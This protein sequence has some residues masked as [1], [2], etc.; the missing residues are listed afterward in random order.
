MK[1][2]R[3]LVKT[4]KRIQDNKTRK[5]GSLFGFSSKKK[6]TTVILS[7]LYSK[8]GNI[9]LK[10]LESKF[11]ENI[12]KLKQR[13][14][15]CVT[16]CLKS[17]HDDK[18]RDQMNTM[19]RNNSFYDWGNICGHSLNVKQCRD[20][21]YTYSKLDAY[22]K[23]VSILSRKINNHFDKLTKELNEKNIV[24]I[25]EQPLGN[26][27]VVSPLSKS[28]SKSKSRS[29]SRSVFSPKLSSNSKSRS[30]SRSVFSPNQNPKSRSTSTSRSS[31]SSRLSDYSFKSIER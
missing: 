29:S 11:T 1:Y 18:M 26:T 3:R 24:K 16:T 31:K 13:K 10:D 20:F 22:N 6:D 25:D 4:K 19:M 17:C 12:D 28:R 7:E 15:Q 27:N 14:S 2:T 30:S 8:A 9:K 5:G 21:I 23:Y